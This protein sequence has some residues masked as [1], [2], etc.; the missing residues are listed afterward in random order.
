MDPVAAVAELRAQVDQP[1]QKLIVIFCAPTYDLAALGREIASGFSAPVVACTAAGL[2]DAQGLSRGGITALSLAGELDVSLFPIRDVHACAPSVADIAA[3]IADRPAGAPGERGFGLL[4]IDGLAKAEERVTA[5]LYQAVG[6]MPIVGGS[7]GDHLTFTETHVF[8]DG[9]FRTNAAVFAVVH[10]TH[11][12]HA[13]KFEHFAPSDRLMVVTRAEGRVVYE[14]DGEPAAD[15]YARLVGVAREA[16]D[17]TVFSAHPLVLE[18][19]GEAFVRSI[20]QAGVDGGLTLLCAIEDGVVLS[21]ADSSDPRVVARDAFDRVEG[22][23]GGPPVVVIGCDCILRRLEYDA[24]DIADPV[25][26]LMRERRVFGF[27]TYGEQFNAMH[28]NQTFT[29][30]ALGA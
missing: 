8:V 30:V 21:V 10:T 28:V 11:P 22:V 4:L 26:Q 29:G 6:A 14:L 17:A 27:S 16:L 13:F 5:A 19:G 25:A 9:A 2:I 1:D 15:V 20:V 3:S 23:L 7:A 12:F 24:K 18:L